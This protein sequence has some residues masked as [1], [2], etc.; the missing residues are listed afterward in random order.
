[1]TDRP[2]PEI[3]SFCRNQRVCDIAAGYGHSMMC[4]DT[5]SSLHTFLC[6]MN[7]M[8]AKYIETFT[9]GPCLNL[10]MVHT[11]LLAIVLLMVLFRSANMTYFFSV[12]ELHLVINCSYFDSPSL[13][14]YR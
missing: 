14:F 8:L 12:V 11:E 1:M 7:N 5:V 9:A 4:T 13:P 10:E 6:Q 2:T 3:I